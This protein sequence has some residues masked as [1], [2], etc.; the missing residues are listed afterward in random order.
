MIDVTWTAAVEPGLKYQNAVEATA[1]GAATQ[2]THFITLGRLL[3]IV[4]HF[5]LRFW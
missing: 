5:R 3:V 2:R 4:S 1:A